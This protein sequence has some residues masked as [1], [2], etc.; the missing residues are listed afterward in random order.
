M[1][2]VED[3]GSLDFVGDY[4]LNQIELLILSKLKARQKHLKIIH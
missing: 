3:P 1:A 2:Q 4:Q